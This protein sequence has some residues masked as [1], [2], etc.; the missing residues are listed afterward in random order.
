MKLDG[1]EVKTITMIAGLF[2]VIGCRPRRCPWQPSVTL[3]VESGAVCRFEG[4][5]SGCYIMDFR[6]LRSDS[7]VTR[8]RFS[9][10]TSRLPSFRDGKQGGLL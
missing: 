2:S 3:N 7:V 1:F 9:E 5:G 4:I 8:S 10:G 6:K